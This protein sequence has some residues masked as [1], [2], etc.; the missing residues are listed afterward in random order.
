MLYHTIPYYTILYY[1]TPY[2]RLHLGDSF[3]PRNEYLPYP[4]LFCYKHDTDISQSRTGMQY[5]QFTVVI[6][7]SRVITFYFG[8][9][10][11]P[12]ALITCGSFFSFVADDPVAGGAQ[13]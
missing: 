12:L 5:P 6:S 2:C 13:Q 3:A 10:I 1:T 9:M 11:F 8:N 4:T 7:V